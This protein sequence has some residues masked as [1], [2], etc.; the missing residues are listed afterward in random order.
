LFCNR[1]T[2][3]QLKGDFTVKKVL[4][5][6]LV[7]LLMA[8]VLA[9]CSSP[10]PAGG[11]E[12]AG[13]YKFAVLAPITGNYAEYGKGF[14][15]ATQMAADEINEAGGINGNM[16]ELVVYDTKGEPTES[17]DIARRVVDDESFLAVLGDFTSSNCMA[18]API[19]GAGGM[20]QLSP[21]AS[22]PDYA[23]M[24]EYMFS[25]M[26]RQD[27]EAPFFSTFLL[28]KYKNAE[29]VGVI[30]INNDWGQSAYENL[31]RQAA[32]D[33]LNIVL[34]KTMLKAKETSTHC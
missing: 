29:A 11:G 26:G 31:T 15:V 1:E 9:G 20:V 21:T 22:H 33:G 34:K 24:N 30:Y 4:S 28:Q 16:I 23:G 5:V 10:A 32:I 19:L 25:I 18:N 7:V 3:Q 27:G 2:D 17:A 13:A 6:L 12:E 8:A 14:E